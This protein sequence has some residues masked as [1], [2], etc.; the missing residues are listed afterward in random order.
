[1][2]GRGARPR[3]RPDVM[4]QPGLTQGLG[5]RTGGGVLAGFQGQGSTKRRRAE[6]ASAGKQMQ[7]AYIRNLPWHYGGRGVMSQGGARFAARRQ[8][9]SQGRDAGYVDLAD[10]TYAMNTTGTITLLATVAQGA[11]INERIGKKAVWKSLQMR[12]HIFG[13]ATTL[14]TKVAFLVVYDKRPTGTLPGITDI[15]EAATPTAFN[16]TQN[17]GRFQILKRV[18]TVL[19]GNNTTAAQ[20]TAATAY[21][22]DF[23]LDLKQKPVVYKAAGTG[24]IGDIEQGALYFITVGNVVAGTADADLQAGFR[25]R[26]NDI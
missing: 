24:A 23:Y 2:S 3:P 25:V 6:G 10:A 4:F 12:G 15:L 11:S 18:D 22:A 14:V 17:E 7:Q 5:R 19:T 26:F 20:Q 9:R 16:N 8:V 21:S 1:M 13:N